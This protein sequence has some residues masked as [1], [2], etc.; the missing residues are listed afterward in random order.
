MYSTI[1]LPILY[2]SSSSSTLLSGVSY[3]SGYTKQPEKN[4]DWQHQETSTKTE[5]NLGSF[6]LFNLISLFL[7]HVPFLHIIL[8]TLYRIQNPYETIEN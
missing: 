1:S 7:F 4:K 2:F 5:N 8:S 3:F 6:S